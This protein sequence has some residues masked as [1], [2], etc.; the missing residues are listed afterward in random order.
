MTITTIMPVFN[1]G[2]WV[3]EAVDSILAQS[4]KDFELI[5]VDD[6]STDRTAEILNGYNDPRIRIFLHH[7]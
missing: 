4:F 2:R 3:S 5:V 7:F 1:G 6:G